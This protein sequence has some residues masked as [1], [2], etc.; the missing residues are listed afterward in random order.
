MGHLRYNNRG[1]VG[2][3][4][5]ITG[6]VGHLRYNNRGVGIKGIITGGGGAFKI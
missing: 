3:K 6:G 1:G 2:I 5:I 4:G